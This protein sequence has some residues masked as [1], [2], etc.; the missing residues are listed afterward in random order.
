MSTRL[1]IR[2]LTA[3]RSVRESEQP[4]AHQQDLLLAQEIERHAVQVTVSFPVVPAL[5]VL[6]WWVV[7]PTHAPSEQLYPFTVIGQS[8]GNHI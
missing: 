2:K 4:H 7:C 3:K 6:L 5:N 1:V 8:L